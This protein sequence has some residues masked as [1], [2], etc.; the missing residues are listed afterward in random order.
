[1]SLRRIGYIPPGGTALDL[2]ASPE[3]LLTDEHIGGS[4]G[5]PGFFAVSELTRA[6][7]SYTAA[8]D[9]HAKYF[10]VDLPIVS[11]GLAVAAA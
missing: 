4:P 7:D 1:M 5:Q 8:Q 6:T 3:S 10:M 9:L 2:S 11:R